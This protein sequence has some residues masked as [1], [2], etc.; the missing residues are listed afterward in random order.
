M[1]NVGVAH[2]FLPGATV[3]SCG[4]RENLERGKK[5]KG[6]RILRGEKE[7]RKVKNTL[8][9]KEKK[10]ERE[11]RGPVKKEMEKDSYTSK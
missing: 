6:K 7:E 10:I 9:M 2:D 11:G 8:R 1:T 5:G 3:G 4:P